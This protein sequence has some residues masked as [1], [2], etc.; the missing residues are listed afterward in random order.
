MADKRIRD[1]QLLADIDLDSFLPFDRTDYLEAKKSTVQDLLD[2]VQSNI[3]AETVLYT[4]STNPDN[5]DGENGDIYIKITSNRLDFYQKEGGAWL[6][7]GFF[8]V[9]ISGL[10]KITLTGA[11]LT[12]IGG[13]FYT[14]PLPVLTEDQTIVGMIKVFPDV[15]DLATF[16][17]KNPEVDGSDLINIEWDGVS[18][19][20]LIITIG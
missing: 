10:T 2:F 18:D 1:L 3:S 19:I 14:T 12:D 15:S 4:G 6:N 8:E 13:G 5:I 20:Q 9:D 7:K 11:D 17:F 16:Y